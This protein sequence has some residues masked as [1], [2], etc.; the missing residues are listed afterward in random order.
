MK[1]RRFLVEFSSP[2]SPRACLG[3]HMIIGF[4]EKNGMH[5]TKRTG[6]EAQLFRPR[7]V[8]PV[9]RAFAAVTS[10]PVPVRAVR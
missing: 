6:C 4:H 3:K 8:L 2:R 9:D 1:P 10:I 7:A 5:V